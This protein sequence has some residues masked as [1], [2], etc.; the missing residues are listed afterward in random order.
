MQ[1]QASQTASKRV[2]LQGKI[3][4]D[5]VYNV[6]L[7][8]TPK[9]TT[10]LKICTNGFFPFP[11][12]CNKTLEDFRRLQQKINRLGLLFFSTFHQ[13]RKIENE[14]VAVLRFCFFTRFYMR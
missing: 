12:S 1:L 10:L 2:I 3:E 5:V 8:N 9:Y 11:H 14:T 6:Q 13:L 4:I 7:K